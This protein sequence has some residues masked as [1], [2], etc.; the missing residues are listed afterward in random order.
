MPAGSACRA[1][2]DRPHRPE[3]R[4]RALI[5]ARIGYTWPCS[6]IVAEHRHC[7]A[8]LVQRLQQVA[9]GRVKMLV[10][11]PVAVLLALGEYAGS[12][13]SIAIEVT[14]PAGDNDTE[15]QHA[16]CGTHAEQLAL[17]AS[18]PGVVASET[19]LAVDDA[20]ET[21]RLQSN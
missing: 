21:G 11:L 20:P 10:Q 8:D 4:S 3:A 5:E 1:G 9:P 13:G 6:A 17:A 18:H 16:Y 14:L 12:L 2:S 19:D 15:R 7:I